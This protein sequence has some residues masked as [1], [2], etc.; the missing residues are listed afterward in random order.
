MR[1]RCQ[2]YH[3]K[4]HTSICNASGDDKSTHENTPETSSLRPEAAVFHFA[5]KHPHS[6]VLLKT[7]I[8]SVGIKETAVDAAILFDEGSQKSFITQQLADQLQLPVDGTEMLNTA[9]VCGKI[10]ES[11]TLIAVQC[12]R[13]QTTTK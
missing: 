9:S 1:G 12:T 13:K 2:Q 3:R 11:D 8:A 10:R 6:G 4:H 5:M 7:T